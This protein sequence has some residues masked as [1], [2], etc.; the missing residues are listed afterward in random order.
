MTIT[1]L[2][3]PTIKPRNKTVPAMFNRSGSGV[4]EKSK[5]AL[6]QQDKIKLRKQGRDY[7]G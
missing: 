6:R 2:L 1:E 3:K 5:K 7:E 4:H